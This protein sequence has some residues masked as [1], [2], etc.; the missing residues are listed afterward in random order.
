[1]FALPGFAA[2]EYAF[3]AQNNIAAFGDAKR[4][5]AALAKVSKYASHNVNGQRRDSAKMVQQY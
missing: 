5:V 2:E 4:A 3:L 1:L